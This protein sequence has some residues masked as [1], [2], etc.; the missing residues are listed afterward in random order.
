MSK[1]NH[2]GEVPRSLT[3]PQRKWRR[4]RVLL[5]AESYYPIIGN[6]LVARSP[7]PG[8]GNPSR[9]LLETR[10]VELCVSHR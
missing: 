9:G 7:L 3:T 10:R 8:V 1:D 5:H 4:Y 6:L 2:R